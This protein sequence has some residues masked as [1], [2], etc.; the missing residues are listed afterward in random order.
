MFLLYGK[1]NSLIKETINKI[2]FSDGER[3]QYDE[4]EILENEKVFFENIL[5]ESRLIK[6]KQ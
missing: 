2:A 4:K 5:V 3:F 6:T 1:N